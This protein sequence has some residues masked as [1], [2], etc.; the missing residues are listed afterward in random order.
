MPQMLLEID[1]NDGMMIWAC[2]HATIYHSAVTVWDGLQ[3]MRV[4]YSNG[5]M[6]DNTPPNVTAATL[7]SRLALTTNLI[8]R[9]SHLVH[10]E[11][12]GIYDPESGVRQ[13]Y[14]AVG[15]PQDGPEYFTEFR[16]IGT[17]EG[18]ILMGGI[19]MADGLL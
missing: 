16:S 3:N 12:R 14:A 6:Y 13:Y 7:T 19:A 2:L 5:V 18:E 15:T 10:A 8:Q 4:C 11:V 17:S 1:M 9:V